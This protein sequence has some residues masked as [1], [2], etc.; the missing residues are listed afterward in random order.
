MKNL[1][2]IKYQK[3]S[4]FVNILMPSI[5]QPGVMCFYLTISLI[6]IWTIPGTIALRNFLILAGFVC[7]I[8]YLI[9]NRI[10]LNPFSS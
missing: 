5:V 2:Q 4:S 7:G 6:V 8:F 9:K 3:V 1:K 10:F